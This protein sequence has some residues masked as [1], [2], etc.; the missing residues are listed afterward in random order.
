MQSLPPAI[1]AALRVPSRV[2]A[3]RRIDQASFQLE[4]TEQALCPLPFAEGEGELEVAN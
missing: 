1:L 2:E 4:G 3:L